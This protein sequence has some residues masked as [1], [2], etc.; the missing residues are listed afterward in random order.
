MK[1]TW[2]VA[3]AFVLGA[4]GVGGAWAQPSPGTTKDT[5]TPCPA[6][7]EHECM[8][9]MSSSYTYAGGHLTGV[10]LCHKSL[11]GGDA[12]CVEEIDPG[13]S[14]VEWTDSRGHHG[15]IKFDPLGLFDVTN[16]VNTFTKE[17]IAQGWEFVDNEGTNCM[18]LTDAAGIT[19]LEYA[20]ES[21]YSCICPEKDETGHFPS[22]QRVKKFVSLYHEPEDAAKGPRDVT[23]SGGL[24]PGV[25]Y[26]LLPTDY[27]NE[28]DFIDYADEQIAMVR[29]IPPGGVVGFNVGVGAAPIGPRPE[30]QL[31][32]WNARD[33][34]GGSDIRLFLNGREIVGAFDGHDLDGEPGRGISQLFRIAIPQEMI[35]EIR[36][37]AAQ[38]VL[39][40]EAPDGQFLGLDSVAVDTGIVVPCRADFDGDG[41]VDDFDLFAF[42]NALFGSEPGADVNG[43]TSVDDFD[44]FDYLN[45]FNAPC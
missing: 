6:P 22:T 41:F 31:K 21:F 27:G 37:P 4:W 20:F 32:V 17:L 29:R 3:W 16:N 24:R 5:T 14:V 23:G 39:L 35:G 28:A 30:F 18:Q 13:Y 26:A 44:F 19:D 25:E 9:R 10:R 34:S 12:P 15:P 36:Q 11:G 33:G 43:D 7:C 8:F 38:L 45:V 42:L 1:R 40:H 2:T